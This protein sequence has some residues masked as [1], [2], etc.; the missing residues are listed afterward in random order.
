MA[1]TAI[2]QEIQN[3]SRFSTIENPEKWDNVILFFFG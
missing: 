1:N 2:A 3:L